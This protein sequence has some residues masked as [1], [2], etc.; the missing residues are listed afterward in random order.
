MKRAD[1]SIARR[2][3]FGSVRYANCWEDADVLVQALAPAKGRR[4]LSIASAGDNSFCLAAEGANVVAVDLSPAQL[5]CVELKMATI[6]HLRCED[7]HAF[8][9]VTPCTSRMETFEELRC[10]LSAGARSFWK[11][12]PRAV[13]QGI[14][15]TGKFEN[16]FRLFRTRALPLIHTRKRVEQ[17]L[18]P[19]PRA[20][21]IDFYERRWN[22]LRW[23]LLFRLFFSRFVMGRLGRDPEFFRYVEGSV[24]DRILTRTR[25]ALTELPTDTNPYLAYILRG[26]F[27]RA[28]PRYLQ[29]ERYAAVRA[30]LDRI[31]LVKGDIAGAAGEHSRGGFDGYNLSDIF[32][33]MSPDAFE[34]TYSALLDTARPG[35][36]L[37]YWNMLV[38]RRRPNG[39]ADRVASLA[40]LSELLFARD[41]AFFYSAFVTEE[42]R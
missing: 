29:P 38:P 37:A 3:D 7:A 6:R 32:E 40:D 35:S 31:T 33:Y 23:R 26:T 1:T 5:A 19:R 25:Y 16:Y 36:R 39:A 13:K 34:R 15:H 21:R 12:R 28:L 20:E 22:N 17:L 24:A 42:V 41:R 4:I 27:G 30:G 9:G 14:I 18:S 10:E 8:L 2:A 11:T